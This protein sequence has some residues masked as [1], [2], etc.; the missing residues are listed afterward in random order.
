MSALVYR[1]LIDYIFHLFYT[2]KKGFNHERSS[3]IN[4]E[5]SKLLISIITFFIAYLCSVTIAGAFKAWV[6]DKMGDDTPAMMGLLTLNPIAHVD[7]FGLIMLLL[8]FFGWGR[9]VPINPFNINDPYRKLK[10]AVAYMADTFAY[11]GAALLG[12]IILVVGFGPKML[13]VAREMLICMQKMTHLFLV[14]ECPTLSS[15]GIVVAFIVIAFAYLN[16]VLGVLTGIMNGVSVS[17]M[18]LMERSSFINQYHNT[19]VIIVPII[20]ILF[21]SEMLRIFAINLISMVGLMIA[22]LL[23]IA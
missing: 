12:I 8:F 6:A 2:D 16:V 14:N 17:M 9:Y 5:T 4:L 7:I 18:M 19:I 10:I 23:P 22:Y 13:F 3:M 1:G 15:F 20:I 11:L 21:F